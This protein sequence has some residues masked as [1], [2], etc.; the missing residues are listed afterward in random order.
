[1]L[2]LISGIE[3]AGT[4]SVKC[5]AVESVDLFK[6]IDTGADSGGVELVKDCSEDGRIDS[7]CECDR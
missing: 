4:I 1:V 3:S 6:R 5:L 7:C 2:R